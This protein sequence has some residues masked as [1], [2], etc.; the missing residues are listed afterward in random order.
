MNLLNVIQGKMV[1]K[2]DKW[3]ISKKRGEEIA[4]KYIIEILHDSTN[5]IT[6]LSNLIILM[7]QI[8][9]H[10]KF[11]NRSKRKPLSVYLRSTYGSILNFLDNFSI[12]G[13]INQESD[14]YVKLLEKN[15]DSHSDINSS[16]IQEYK[17]WI[18]I[19]DEDFILV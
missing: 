17:E 6:S 1:H 8:T 2:N 10:I 12:Y 3:N 13:I 11:I 16:I 4:H 18:I 14:I 7:N 5:N 19:D 9:K 15:I